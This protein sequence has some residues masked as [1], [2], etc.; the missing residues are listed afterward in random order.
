VTDFASLIKHLS[1]ES[2][3]FI[4][5]GGFAGTIHGAARL[6]VDLDV[7]YSRTPE[8]IERLAAALSELEPYLRGAPPGLP[9]KFDVSTIQRGMNFTLT[10]AVGDLD[11]LGEVTGGGSY[12]ELLSSTE[13]VTVFEETVR[14]LNLEKLIHVKRAAGRPKDFEAIAEL[15]RLNELDDPN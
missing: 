9:F 10:T 2:V 15:E 6:T 8:N 4:V 11:L 1:S 5:I 3:E 14:C 13:L 7:V 12:E